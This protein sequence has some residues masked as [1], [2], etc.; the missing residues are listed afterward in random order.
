[1]A[2]GCGVLLASVGC[3]SGPTSGDLDAA[4]NALR[5]IRQE[6]FASGVDT[7][8]SVSDDGKSFAYERYQEGNYDIWIKPTTSSSDSSGRQITFHSTDDRRPTW[9]GSETILFDSWRVDLNKLWRKKATGTGGITLVSRGN[10]IDMD[11]DVS[12]TG[13]IVFVSQV[14]ESVLKRDRKG[15]LWR[16]YSSMPTIWVLQSDGALTML[17]K[18]ISPA[19]S[20]DGTKIAF[21]S[22]THG[23]YDIFIMDKDGGNQTQVTSNKAIDL[24]PCWSPDGRH[25]AFTSDRSSGRTRP[26]FNI[27]VVENDGSSP[28]QMTTQR[29]TEGGPSWSPATT[30]DPFGRI[31]FHSYVNRDW[32]IWSV[33]A[34]LE[35]SN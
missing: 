33:G 16:L 12:S 13:D 29:G 15:Q 27:W 20:P 5:D 8:P 22:N 11:A 2:V 4:E 19:W 14:S 3:A 26:D 10:H 17:G 24:E 21:A 25:I 9:M 28:T 34:G 31:Y 35:P 30:K 32:N 6:T 23:S 7:Y 18:G 1:M